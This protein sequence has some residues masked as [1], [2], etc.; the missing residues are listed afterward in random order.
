MLKKTHKMR[1]THILIYL[2]QT[3]IKIG[4]DLHIIY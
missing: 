4:P 2:R 1:H 3:A